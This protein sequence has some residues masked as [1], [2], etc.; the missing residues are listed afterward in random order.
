MQRRRG[1]AAG[2]MRLAEHVAGILNTE[3]HWVE[4]DLAGEVLSLVV[5]LW[6]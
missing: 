5:G 2:M 1:D 6:D 3:K 4:K